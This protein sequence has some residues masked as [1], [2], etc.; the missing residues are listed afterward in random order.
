MLSAAGSPLVAGSIPD[1]TMQP[2]IIELVLLRPIYIGGKLQEKG[3]K[4]TATKLFA[5]ELI[6]AGKA[7]L[8]PASAPEAPSKPAAPAGGKK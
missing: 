4:L 8:A 5:A 3:K 6:G 2:T 7:E 1:T